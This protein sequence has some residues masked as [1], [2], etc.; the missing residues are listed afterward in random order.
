MGEKIVDVIRIELKKHA[1][2]E[3]HIEQMGIVDIRA[4]LNEEPDF[5][6]PLFQ[7]SMKQGGSSVLIAIVNAPACLQQTLKYEIA[8]TLSG[9][10]DKRLS[11][12]FRMVCM[13]NQL[14][15]HAE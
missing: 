6:V 11:R 2:Y 7:S 10:K 15:D 3:K 1:R 8:I 9:M 5:M 13:Q 12:L 4:M 14:N